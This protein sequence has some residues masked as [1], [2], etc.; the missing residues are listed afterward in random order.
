MQAIE[1]DG[2]KALPHVAGCVSLGR[3]A[4]FS[5][6]R[7]KVQLQQR[8]VLPSACVASA[9]RLTLICPSHLPCSGPQAS[10]GKAD[11]WLTVQVRLAKQ[12]RDHADEAVRTE[13]SHDLGHHMVGRCTPACAHLCILQPQA[14]G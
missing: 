13:P 1:A 10:A 11:C 3:M 5:D 9:G 7:S 8:Q 2:S 12:A 4:L 6:N 14:M